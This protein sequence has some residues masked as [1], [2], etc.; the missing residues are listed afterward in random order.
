MRVLVLMAACALTV[1]NTRA[2]DW[3]DQAEP[4]T[5]RFRTIGV[6]E[7]LSQ[8]SVTAIGQ[9]RYGFLWF[10]T[11]DGLNRF[12]GESI[13]IYRRQMDNVYGLAGNRI[14]A[15]A[16]DA[17]GDLWIGSSEGLSRY[18]AERDRFEQ[19]SSALPDPFVNQLLL[20]PNGVIWIGTEGGLARLSD[21]GLIEALP[22]DLLADRRARALAL[23]RQG[24]L[25]IGTPTGIA[26]LDTNSLRTLELRINP[27]SALSAATIQNV[28]AL[29]MDR[30]GRLW[31]GTNTDGVLVYHPDSGMLHALSQMLGHD[32]EPSDETIYTLHQDRAGRIWVGNYLGL[33]LLQGEPDKPWRRLPFRHRPHQGDS[34]GSGRVVSV[35][36]DAAGGLWFGSWTGG[37]SML[38]PHN[39]RF[40][41]LDSDYLSA[42]GI[43]DGFVISLNTGRQGKLWVSTRGGLF[44]LETEPLRAHRLAAVDG[45]FVYQLIEDEQAY[46]LATLNG[47]K[48]VARSDPTRMED[49]DLP[50][51]RGLDAF[52]LHLDADRLWVG[53]VTGGLF[54]ADHQ[55]H[56]V[57]ARYPMVGWVSTITAYSDTLMLVGAE[58]GLFWFDRQSM[59]LL[60]HERGGDVHEG[61]L[62]SGN[63]TAFVRADD[64]REWLASFGD[65]LYQLQLAKTDHPSQARYVG[66]NSTTGLANDVIAAMYQGRDGKLWLATNGGISSFDPDNGRFRNY[67]AV[68]GVLSDGYLT[69]ASTQLPDGRL[70]FGGAG[71]LNLFDPQQLKAD[72]AAAPALFTALEL[73]GKRFDVVAQG[74]SPRSLHASEELQIPAS[75]A[76]S[77]S[78]HFA[79]PSFIAPG[80]IGYRYRARPFDVDW[81][82]AAA[83]R[84]LATYTN[85]APGRYQFEVQALNPSGEA[86]GSARELGLTIVPPWWQTHAARM[87]LVALLIA[88]AWA[89]YRGRMRYLAG[90]REQL[91]REVDERTAELSHTV[92]QLRNTQRSLVEQE[93]MASLGALVAG[94]AHEINT[95]VGVAMT[96]GSHLGVLTRTANQA[97]EQGALTRSALAGYFGEAA[98]TAEMI[99][100][101][102]SRAAELIS[103][104]KQ[105]SV[106]RTADGRR[107]FYLHELISELLS[108]VRPMWRRRPINIEVRC[109]ENLRMDSFPG[110]L[111]QVFSN[112]IQNALIHA[113]APEQV[114][115]IEIACAELEHDRVEV[116]FSDNGRGIEAQHLGRIF[117]PF[118]TTRRGQG[119]TG[120][121][122]HLVFNLVSQKLGGTLSVESAPAQGTHFVLVMPRSAPA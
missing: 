50:E 106:D 22:T 102:L 92:E 68:D 48:R 94:V 117:D 99:E 93:K 70:A 97:F 37:A 78:L 31:M 107:E 57:L 12:D 27:E 91:Q 17:A 122:L 16:A 10:G 108:S 116:R 65:G 28:F 34:L 49:I 96:A 29:L 89:A 25:W 75:L 11:Q 36:D 19:L 38:H 40:G 44:R 62:R 104:F 66:H 56:D 85:L 118:F 71:G 23:D 58:N 67:F 9:D 45:D 4:R 41:R 2:D 5:L 54:V 95:P 76:R 103:N 113:F 24:R 110:T 109:P 73:A 112:L 105:V 77:L 121:G 3:L 87:L 46:W 86:I 15:I 52:A 26:C 18:D 100:R 8:R 59:Q 60:H 39:Q 111:G 13:R 83:G 43:G 55:G 61:A 84:N 7:G 98:T 79:S 51:L 90:Q 35:F 115:R 47:V 20:A 82:V 72:P 74:W 120:L 21:G 32:A 63:I 14:T 119:S 42:S 53:T 101:N 114:G 33:D 69:R 64:G 81:N 80:A 1:Q 6:A 88:L 30:D